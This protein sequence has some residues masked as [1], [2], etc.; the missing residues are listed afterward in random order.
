MQR[1]EVEEPPPRARRPRAARPALRRAR[2]C[3]RRN[4]LPAAAC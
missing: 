4:S 1:R 3:I 2:A